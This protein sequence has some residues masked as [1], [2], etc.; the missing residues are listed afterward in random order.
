[1]ER[2]PSRPYP[3]SP[4]LEGARWSQAGGSPVSSRAWGR[5][6]IHDS[7]APSARTRSSLARRLDGL[8]EAVHVLL[9][10][11]LLRP[12]LDRRLGQL[13]ELGH[14][15]RRELGDLHAKLR[16]DLLGV[17]VLIARH[18]AVDGRGLLRAFLHRLPLDGREALVELLVDRVAVDAPDMAV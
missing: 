16:E 1:M 9:A 7:S 3:G 15:G 14:L 18:L 5:G 6:I 13:A 17:L 4:R 10:D 12:G 8:E 11:L 2:L